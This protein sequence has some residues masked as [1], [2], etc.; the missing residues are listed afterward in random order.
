[1]D[2]GS[3]R[4]VTV[5]DDSGMCHSANLAMC[6]CYDEGIMRNTNLMVPCE[7]FEEAAAMIRE[8]PG[9][10]VGLHSTLNAEWDD[11]RWKWG[12]V[13]APDEVPSLVNEEGQFFQT[14]QA[15][16]DN[17]PDPDEML[18]EVRAQLELARS[19][20][21]TVTFLSTHMGWSW[22]RDMESRLEEFARAEGLIFRP[23]G[24]TR[25]PEAPA[26]TED[27]IEGLKARLEAAAPGT[28][29]M[30]GHP[31][32]DDEEMARFGHNGYRR[33]AQERDRDRRMMTD[34]RIVDYCRQAGIRPL[35]MDEV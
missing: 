19:E 29:Y 7:E 34:P 13:L 1:M 33:V 9:L 21:L 22:I 17:D 2:E 35:R 28:Y 6:E 23:E 30:G 32:Y 18:A 24:V 20:G 25:L 14:T 12:P 8:R 15:L 27:P 31:G 26:E 3:I 4:L 5:G 16:N 11:P 10:C